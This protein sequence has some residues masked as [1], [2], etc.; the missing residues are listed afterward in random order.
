MLDHSD[1][2]RFTYLK[3]LS[4]KVVMQVKPCTL[5]CICKMKF[6]GILGLKLHLPMGIS[7][8]LRNPDGLLSPY[9]QFG[10]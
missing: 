10:K 6:I 1:G 4:T 9:Y 8:V 2:M 5:S 3:G 7:N